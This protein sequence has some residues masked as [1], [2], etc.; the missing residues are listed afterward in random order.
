MDGFAVEV[1]SAAIGGVGVVASIAIGLIPY[2]RRR[3]A[4]DVNAQ[5]ELPVE[6]ESTVDSESVAVAVHKSYLSRGES[7]LAG[8]SLYSPDGRTKFTLQDNANIVVFVA[9]RDICDTRTTNIGK[10][11]CLTLR[12]DG[13]L[14]LYDVNEEVLWKR[15]PGGDH[16]DVQDNSHVVLYPTVGAEPVWATQFFFKAG[17]LM[18]W[19]P[20]GERVGF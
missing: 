18:R 8:Q 1:L 16:L 20:L 17:I 2:M 14:V 7:L 4:I 13:W 3:K 15:G 6:S 10:P 5:L 19:V 11:K 12:E 9:G